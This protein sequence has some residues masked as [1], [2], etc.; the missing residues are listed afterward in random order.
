MKVVVDASVAVKWVLPDPKAELDADQAVALLTKIK[1]GTLIPLQPPHWLAEVT[2]VITRLHPEVAHEAVGL[3]DAL[4]LAVTDD[5]DT[6]LRASA[7]GTQLRCH[8]FDALYHAVALESDAALITADD[9]YYRKARHLG[10]MI[11]LWMLPTLI[12]KVK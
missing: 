6:F 2:A 10:Q 7:I 9:N 1:D 4:D 11:R 12:A 8:V 3:L 5:L